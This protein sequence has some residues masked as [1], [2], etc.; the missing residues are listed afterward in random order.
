MPQVL[1]IVKPHGSTVGLIAP[2][3]G[4]VFSLDS[5]DRRFP[6]TDVCTH[7]NYMKTNRKIARYFIPAFVLLA[8]QP[9]VVCAETLEEAVFST[10]T[11]H[12]NVA[13]AKAA[14]GAAAQEKREAKS[15]YFPTVSVG[16]TT[17][18]IYG[19]NATSRGLSVTRGAGYS[20]LWNSSISARE[21]I[22]K[23]F[24]TSN[25]IDSAK[26]RKL[27][28]DMNVLDVKESLAYKAAQ[29]YI[30]LMRAKEGL[31]LLNG[32]GKKVDD[33]L[34]RIKKM[35][36]EGASDEAEYQQ[37]RDIRVILDG[38]VVDYEAQVSAA[39]SN[40]FDLTGHLPEGKLERPVVRVEM[41]PPTV[42]EAVAA[43][44]K[45]HPTLHAAQYTSKSAAYDVAAE[46]APLYPTLEGE[47]SYLTEEKR[48]LIGGELED[49]RA[50]VHLSWDYET[51]GA[52]LARIKRKKFEHAEAL[53]R[54]HE[55]ERQV[56]LGVRLAWSE[57]KSARDQTENQN[58]RQSLNKK[59]F[60]TY[61]AQFE[62]TKISLL[63]LM[64][65]DNQL[66]TTGLEKL[67]GQYRLLAS[68]Y[69]ILSSM[70]RLQQ[71]L[72][73]ASVSPAPIAA[74]PVIPVA[75]EPQAGSPV[76]NK[77]VKKTCGPL[78]KP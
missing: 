78:K 29:A 24:E 27:S 21:P 58:K 17:G 67:N 20:N 6:S 69:A 19:D 43:A 54:V 3:P 28:A 10:I 48:D 47:L 75:V 37:A 61:K 36:D 64:Q 26:S 12:P 73:L 5:R 11:T 8:M 62:G 15:D 16:A 57:Y 31:A 35:V 13:E 60:D 71:S 7:K 76:E 1:T 39:E 53:S 9:A 40:Y 65:G 30:D 34:N 77:C 25:R 74:A 22:F 33:Y 14:S 44:R 56:E 52:Q 2:C 23:G 66:F 59:L 70:G 4:I 50:V 18:R 68:E 51:G 42:E 41:I 32:H 38:L 63:Q 72:N 49:G 45:Y 55:T 46:K